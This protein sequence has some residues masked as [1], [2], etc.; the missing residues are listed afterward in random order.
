MIIK[1][2]SLFKTIQEFKSELR[3]EDTQLNGKMFENYVKE[4]FIQFGYKE[5][6]KN[7]KNVYSF[8]Q[9]IRNDMEETTYQNIYSF[10]DGKY[11]I[12][13][14]FGSQCPP[15]IMLF[16]VTSLTIK[17]QCIEVKTGKK[18]ATWN[19]TYPKKGWIYIFSGMKGITWFKGR[20]WITTEQIGI[21]ETYK[22]LRKQMTLEFN[23]KLKGSHLKLVDYF[24]F[25]HASSV[26][27]Y[28]SEQTLREIEVVEFMNNYDIGL[29]D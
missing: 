16:Y 20:H 12:Q 4:S 21:L 23:D 24:K 17:V 5:L 7:D 28:D 25:E 26:D 19:N 29:S 27:Y 2:D 3:N 11:I 14:P 15:D 10:V 22:N 8:L 1:M 13:Q 18:Y 9:N 6:S